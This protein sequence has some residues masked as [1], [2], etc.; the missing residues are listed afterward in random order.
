MRGLVNPGGTSASTPAHRPDPDH[1]RTLKAVV[2]EALQLAPETTV[3][4]QQLACA[5]PDCPPVETVIAVLSAPR[6][7]WKITTPAAD[8][9]AAELDTLLKNCPEGSPHDHTD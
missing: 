4:V 9:S 2:R 3:V 5:E 1:V 7:T 8:V 6:R